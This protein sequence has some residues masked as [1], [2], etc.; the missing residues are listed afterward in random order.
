MP[1]PRKSPDPPAP[2]ER[3]LIALEERLRRL[4][5]GPG[6]A[7]AVRPDPVDRSWVID[8]LR[9]RAAP[10]PKAG[11]SGGRVA[12]AGIVYGG[13]Q[14]NYQWLGERELAPLFDLPWS[15][16]SAAFEALGHGVRLELLRAMA[17]GVR[18]VQALGALPSMKTSGQ[19][20]HHLR[21]LVA[22]G[23][24]RQLQRNH[25]AIVPDRMVALMIIIAAASGPHPSDPPYVAPRARTS[26]RKE[27]S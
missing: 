6:R 14:S 19:L 27:K 25:Y 16:W 20:Y 4:E 13:D 26:T 12:Y 23:W 7:P 15:D 11:Q 5:S 10:A 2:L 9:P 8:G 17:R 22:S 3:R 21:S 18:D 1:K 24:V